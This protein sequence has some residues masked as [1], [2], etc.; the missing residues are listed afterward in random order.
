MALRACRD[1]RWPSRR[2]QTQRAH[3]EHSFMARKVESESCMICEALNAKPEIMVT[4]E[5]RN[6]Y[7]HQGHSQGMGRDNLGSIETQANLWCCGTGLVLWGE[8]NRYRYIE[9]VEAFSIIIVMFIITISLAHR[10]VNLE[11]C[12]VAL[13]VWNSG[14][15]EG[16]TSSGSE[17]SIMIYSA[18]FS[19]IF[20]SFMYSALHL[21]TVPPI[22]N[23]HRRYIGLPGWCTLLKCNM[24]DDISN[25]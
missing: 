3:D 18:S 16:R 23:A 11:S 13:P 12:D 14:P 6:N 9:K 20:I 10:D 17:L 25:K 15:K 24:T 1:R 22:P 2:R 5:I 21:H 19:F 8:T 4:I 7:S